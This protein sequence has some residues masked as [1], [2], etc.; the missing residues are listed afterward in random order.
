MSIAVEDIKA[1]DDDTLANIGHAIKHESD[2]RLREARRQAI[3]TVRDMMATHNLTVA[4]L[5]ET[6]KGQR[7]DRPSKSVKYRH[8]TDE[9]TWSGIGRKPEWLKSFLDGGGDLSSLDINPQ[10]RS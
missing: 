2:L 10:K 8:P 6:G 9:R 7:A 5:A 3:K 4:D 1:L